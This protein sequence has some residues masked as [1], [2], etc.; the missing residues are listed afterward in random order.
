MWSSQR[1]TYLSETPA[2]PIHGK[3][4]GLQVWLPFNELH[5]T[6]V[7]QA[8]GRLVEMNANWHTPLGAHALDFSELYNQNKYPV[9][10]LIGLNW[11]PIGTR[12][13]TVE[14]WVK[15]GTTGEKQSV[16]AINGTYAP[17]ADENRVG[18]GVEFDDV[19][20][21]VVK[22]GDL[23]ELTTPAPLSDAWHPL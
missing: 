9:P 11:I 19:G 12:N 5:G 6:P 7:E 15:P 13:T 3:E 8:R 23:N 2:L 4:L 10:T 21:L 18:W 16:M 20:H 1:E 17:N 22:N 14:L